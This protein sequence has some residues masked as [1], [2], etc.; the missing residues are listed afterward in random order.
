MLDS[1]NVQGMPYDGKSTIPAI[2]EYRLFV[3]R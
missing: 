1:E 2:I 3:L